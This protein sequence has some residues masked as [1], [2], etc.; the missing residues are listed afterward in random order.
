MESPG[1]K[2]TKGLKKGFGRS[3]GDALALSMF[4]GVSPFGIDASSGGTHHNAAPGR[5]GHS[6]APSDI[7]SP[8]DRSIKRFGRCLGAAC[9]WAGGCSESERS[10]KY[11]DEHDATTAYGPTLCVCER[12]RGRR[13][14]AAAPSTTIHQVH[15]LSHTFLNHRPAAGDR[16]RRLRRPSAP[17]PPFIQTHLNNPV[18]RPQ[19]PPI[20]RQAPHHT[21]ARTEWRP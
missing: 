6:V 10:I 11:R 2:E 14:A 13:P 8:A 12:G 18:D 1:G 19:T 17:N 21:R 4:E 9:R 5:T 20:D 15:T 3:I 7:D 16:R